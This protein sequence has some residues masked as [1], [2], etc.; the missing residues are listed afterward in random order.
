[1]FGQ[2]LWLF[3]HWSGVLDSQAPPSLEH[4]GWW[5]AITWGSGVVPRPS[6]CGKWRFRLGSPSLKMVHNPG[7]DWN[8]GRGDNPNY[9]IADVSWK[10]WLINWFVW[11]SFWGRVFGNG[12]C[13]VTLSWKRPINMFNMVVVA[14]LIDRVVC[15]IFEMH[16]DCFLFQ[17]FHL[18]RCACRSGRVSSSQA[19]EKL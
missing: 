15:S 18:W 2:P 5:L 4:H 9:T 3:S 14:A 1:M 10:G 6:N 17:E 19:A 13:H 11:Q 12:A 16:F 8:P 7:G